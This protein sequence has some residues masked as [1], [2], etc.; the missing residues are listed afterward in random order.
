MALSITVF[1]YM[2]EDLDVA[3]TLHNSEDE[4]KFVEISNDINEN[5]LE[6]AEDQ[7]TKQISVR[8]DSGKSLSFMISPT[9]I[10]YITIKISAIAGNA[11]DRIEKKLLV[12]AEG[13]TEH[14]NKAFFIDLSDSSDYTTEVKI[15][16]P[17]FAVSNSTKIEASVIGDVMGP[18]LKN[19]D[20]LIRLPSGCGEQNMLNFVPNIVVL[21]YLTAVEQLDDKLKKKSI[22]YLEKGYQGELT[23]K[24][25]DGSYS[26]FGRGQGSTWLTAFVAKSFNQASR[27]ISIE[28]SIVSEALEF[29]SQQQTEEGNF[30]ENG[31]ILAKSMQGGVAGKGIGLTAYTLITFLE[32][33]ELKSKYERA[34]KKALNYI[35]EH[36]DDHNDAYSM[37]I[38]SYTLQLA[39]HPKKNEVLEK[40]MSN[41]KEKDGLKYWEREPEN[42]TSTDKIW[43]YKPNS[44]NIEITAYALLALVEAGKQAESIPIMKWLIAQRNE[45]GGFQS[46][47]DTVVGLQALAKTT[48][49]IYVANTDLA[50]SIEYDGRESNINVNKKNSLVLQ[51]QEIPSTIKTINLKALGQGLVLAQISYK[52]NVHKS[53][54]REWFD[55]Q[56]TLQNNSDVDKMAVKVCTKFLPGSGEKVSNMAVMEVQLPSGFSYDEDSTKGLSMVEG[57]EVR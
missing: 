31:S 35:E 7:M 47:Q 27:Y 52:F 43:S 3:V 11:G 20:K 1:N 26:T 46:T 41:S 42:E 6:V 54:A 19:L 4:L 51:K 53:E 16:V 12:E 18:A 29:L 37:A 13:V 23:Y 15:E 14:V 45:H 33:K 5:Y 56:H 30:E 21:D 22:D 10:G 2:T 28:D 48:E 57:F 34:I 40:L 44:V 8:S 24:H 32:N 50:V 36:L 25:S 38:T 49:K 9:K 39:D 55:I 17:E